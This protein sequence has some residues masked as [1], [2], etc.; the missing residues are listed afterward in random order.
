M[1]QPTPGPIVL[2][3]DVE[4]AVRDTLKTWVP[5]YLAD[6]DDQQDRPR[7]GPGATVPPR[8]WSIASENDRW[9]EETAP[10][11]LVACPGTMD[12]PERHGAGGSYGAWYQVNI[13]VTASGATE[14]GSRDLVSRH[15]G[16]VVYTLAQQRTMGGLVEDTEWLGH[17]ADVIDRDRKL[18]AVEILARV[19]V[20]GVVDTRGPLIPRDVPPTPTD[21]A[22][23]T[24]TPHTARVTV[25]T[26]RP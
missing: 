17:R 20:G 26:R 16:A 5:F 22:A 8:S 7:S 3:A 14:A 24:P 1:A 18:A 21:P 6:I 25:T 10:A 4:T 23:P 12:Q 11:L 2:T 19:Y 13:G 9:L 15:A